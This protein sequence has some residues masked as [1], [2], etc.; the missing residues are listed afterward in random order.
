MSL[1]KKE[2]AKGWGN[3]QIGTRMVKEADG[4]RVWHMHLAPVLVPSLLSWQNKP[5]LRQ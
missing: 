3:D 1:S 2:I 5:D 4:F